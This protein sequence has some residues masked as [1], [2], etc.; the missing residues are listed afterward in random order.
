MNVRETSMARLSPLLLTCALALAAGPAWPQQAGQPESRGVQPA[1]RPVQ[2]QA[3]PADPGQRPRSASPVP[4]EGPAKLRPLLPPQ[5]R[6]VPDPSPTR[7]FDAGGQ[8][9]DGMLRVGPERAF[10]P[11][12]GRYYRT[13]SDGK[14]VDPPP[15]DR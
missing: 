10:D 11:A 1:P 9:L 4:S 15:A 2:G 14:L 13:T 5:V 12:T 8:P 7:G 3:V 6:T